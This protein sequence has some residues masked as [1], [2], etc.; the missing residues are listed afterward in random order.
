MKTCQCV[1]D[2]LAAE[3]MRMAEAIDEDKWYLS[4]RAGHDVG[5]SVAELHFID[6]FLCAFAHSFRINYCLHCRNSVHCEARP[7]EM[8]LKAG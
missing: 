4:E 1:A 2:Y 8:V 3:R 5:Y 6:H 7:H